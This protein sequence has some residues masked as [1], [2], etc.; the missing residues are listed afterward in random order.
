MWPNDFLLLSTLSNNSNRLKWKKV[1]QIKIFILI[2]LVKRS[3]L[4]PAEHCLWKETTWKQGTWVKGRKKY[5]C[6]CKKLRMKIIKKKSKQCSTLKTKA[7]PPGEIIRLVT[8]KSRGGFLPTLVFAFRFLWLRRGHWTLD[9][10]WVAY[11]IHTVAE[12]GVFYFSPSTPWLLFV[13]RPIESSTHAL[14][15][16]Q[17][18]HSIASFPAI[19]DANWRGSTRSPLFLSPSHLNKLRLD[20]NQLTDI[21]FWGKY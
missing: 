15:A 3:G 14:T 1:G 17:L 11:E 13:T 4:A 2:H 6:K 9:T 20:M 12:N 18:S 5:C 21:T 8:E 19:Y 16:A 7:S 10:T